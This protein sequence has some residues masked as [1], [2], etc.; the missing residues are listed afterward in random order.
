[1]RDLH[2]LNSLNQNNSRGAK[3]GAQ[4]KLQKKICGG[5][6]FIHTPIFKLVEMSLNFS[7]FCYQD[8][9]SYVKLI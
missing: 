3:I 7:E 1:M 9:S 5:T 2:P 4:L 6:E 8:R